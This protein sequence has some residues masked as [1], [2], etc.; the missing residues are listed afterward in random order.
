MKLNIGYWSGKYNSEWEKRMKWDD[1]IDGAPDGMNRYDFR[2]QGGNSSLFPLGFFYYKDY[3]TWTLVTRFNYFH[4]SIGYSFNGLDTNFNTSN[5]HLQNAYSSDYELDLGYRRGFLQNK[6]YTTGR[7]GF[8]NH[9]KNFVQNE[10]I[11]GSNTLMTTWKGEMNSYSF[12]PYLGLD[13]QYVV[14]KNFS[15]LLDVQLP[16]PILDNSSPFSSMNYKLQRVGNFNG[17]TYIELNNAKSLYSYQLTRLALG[18]EI[19]LTEKWKLQIGFR[20][21]QAQVKYS[22]YR[23]NPWIIADGGTGENFSAEPS[24]RYALIENFLDKQN[25]E[26]S[27]SSTQSGVYIS[28]SYQFDIGKSDSKPS[29]KQLKSKK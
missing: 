21:E 22:N 19:S 20:Q 4:R 25:Y 23:N 6:L 16:F 7:L 11:H 9:I 12:H 3:S 8:R 2:F 14:N 1:L 18:V 24:L 10:T 15:L 28:T 13:F 5:V 27:I 17:R 29:N 26:R